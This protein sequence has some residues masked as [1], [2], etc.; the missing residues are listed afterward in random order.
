MFKEKKWKEESAKFEVIYKTLSNDESSKI[1]KENY[2][3]W[4]SAIAKID[5]NRAKENK[6]PVGNQG[7]NNIAYD[8]INRA[9]NKCIFF[10]ISK[11]NNLGCIFTKNTTDSR[12]DSKEYY[13]CISSNKK[14]VDTWNGTTKDYFTNRRRSATYKQF[15]FNAVYMFDLTRRFNFDFEDLNKE[16]NQVNL[17]TRPPEYDI[18]KYKWT[19]HKKIRN[20]IVNYLQF[21]I[22]SN[23]ILDQGIIG[24][25]GY[26]EI[27][28]FINST[29]VYDDDKKF[30][31]KFRGY[32]MSIDKLSSDVKSDVYFYFNNEDINNNIKR[33]YELFPQSNVNLIEEKV[34]NE[35]LAGSPVVNTDEDYDAEVGDIPTTGAYIEPEGGHKSNKRR[36][37]TKRSKSNKRRNTTKRRKSIRRK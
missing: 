20:I 13:V 25:P 19:H 33:Y 27:L 23:I 36:K 28:L 22:N 11:L 15:T 10:Y 2:I 31:T 17:F 21:D 24:Y 34:P 18:N 9:V 3:I 32:F 7:G 14:T 12:L 26:E 35:E 16:N 30:M 29:N 4:Y 5:R 37:T 1:P 8:K 6:P